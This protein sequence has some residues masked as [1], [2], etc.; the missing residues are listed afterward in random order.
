MNAA[1]LTE[2]QRKRCWLGLCVEHPPPIER[3]ATSL[4]EHR[5]HA[6]FGTALCRHDVEGLLAAGDTIEHV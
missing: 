5:L 2:K 6:I 4:A 3:R 1:Y